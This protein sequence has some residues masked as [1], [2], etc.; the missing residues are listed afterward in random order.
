MSRLDIN[1]KNENRFFNTWKL[2]E[3]MA[4]GE[5]RKDFFAAFH[6]LAVRLV[7][8]EMEVKK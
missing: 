2:C 4:K 1:Q 8:S 5:A 7:L 6:P 3:T